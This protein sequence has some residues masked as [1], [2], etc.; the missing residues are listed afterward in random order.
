[1]TSIHSRLA[2]ILVLIAVAPLACADNGE[3]AAIIADA[4]T[5][6]VAAAAASSGG[7]PVAMAATFGGIVILGLFSALMHQAQTKWNLFHAQNAV[8]TARAQM[9]PGVV[10]APPV[11]TV[12]APPAASSAP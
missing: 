1:M 9:P 3:N 2:T 6:G 8:D 5:K 4:I 7:G 12:P 11:V 10:A